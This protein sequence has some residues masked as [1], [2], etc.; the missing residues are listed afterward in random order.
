MAITPIGFLRKI[1]K[2]VRGGV[3]PSQV[4]L[5][6]LLGSLIGLTPGVNG[7]L[8]IGIALVILLNANGGMVV[9]GLALG[10]VLCIAAAPVTFEIGYALIHRAGIE[11]LFRAAAET[12]VVAWMDLHHYCLTGGL[13]VGIVLGIVGGVLLGQLVNGIRKGVVAAGDHSEKLQKLTANPIVRLVM[14][15]VFGKK[16]GA[17]DELAGRK[18]PLIRKAGLIVCALLVVAVL[19]GQFLLVDV[20]FQDALRDG[21][22]G[23]VGAEVNVDKASLSLLGGRLD[24]HG[25]QVTDPDKPTHNLF[26]AES[27][28]GHVS[29][30]GLL[31][32]RLIVDKLQIVDARGDA[33]RSAPGEVFAK[34]PRPEP[35][36]SDDDLSAYFDQARQLREWLQKA[37][38][39]LDQRDANEPEPP[40][41]ED[42][43]Q[44]KQRLR[45]LARAQGYFALSA[46][47]IL[48][49]RPACVIR[50]LDVRPLT[51]P[52]IAEPLTVLGKE[53]STSPQRHD[54]PASLTITAG[55]RTLLATRLDFQKPD[56]EHHLKLDLPPMSIRDVGL[57][58]RAGLDVSDGTAEV[59]VDDG[60]FTNRTITKLPFAVTLRDLKAS[61][62]QG[63]GLCG[64]DPKASA[65][66][67]KHLQKITL[68][69]TLSGPLTAPKL[70]LDEKAIL[71]A[72]KDAL[73]GAGK[74]ELAK[75]ADAQIQKLGSQVTRKVG[76]EVGKAVGDTAGGLLKGVLGG[77]KKDANEPKKD[78]PAG[79]DLFKG[80]LNRT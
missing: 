50:E 47:G 63:K 36:P 26:Q 20:F 78:K 19:A 29:V 74:A 49:R 28:V 72:M 7:T 73:V 15:V 60:I 70:T 56:G 13:A 55:E 27:L 32:K 57:S 5:G 11:G 22:A 34:A 24:V 18:S 61:A 10:K 45:D 71:T 41:A 42:V 37:Q 46:Q 62:K 14:R 64:L 76:G 69:G 80:L 23:A 17:L 31:T 1:G 35:P 68:G 52:Q 25:L 65:E 21:L 40:S 58:D 8:L 67:L 16:K 6:F 77:D 2:F 33:K 9:L 44:D 38:E 54:K 30:S 51:V 12:P 48:S 39:Y 75:Q 79:G 59:R 4:F 66:A 3:T 53:L 43:E